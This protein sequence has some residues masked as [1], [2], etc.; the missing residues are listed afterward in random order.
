MAGGAGCVGG[1]R[2]VTLTLA[3]KIAWVLIGA[4]WFALRYPHERRARRTRVALNRKLFDER[5]R[6]AISLSGLLIVPAV[7]VAT[8]MPR[9]AA[10]EPSGA[11]FAAGLLA[12]GAAL[13]LFRLT[14]KALGKLWSVSLEIKEEHRLVATGIYRHVRHP[15]YLAFWLLAVSQALLLPNWIAGPAG[16]IGF[17]FLFF[18]RIGPEERMMEQ[19]FGND[20][21]AYRQRSWRI[22]P[23]VY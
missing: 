1:P 14:H 8:G 6:M 10:Y 20:Y 11:A 12:G 16:L 13:V 7:Y 17:G 15:M 23:F 22:I 5:V 21:Q 9:F 2:P 3:G 4:V 18:S 19:T